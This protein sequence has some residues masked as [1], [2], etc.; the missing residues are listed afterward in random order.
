MVSVTVQAAAAG[1]EV[2]NLESQQEDLQREIAALRTEFAIQTS[3]SRMEKRAADLGFQAITPEDITYVIIPGYKGREP[4]VQA[5]PPGSSI[6]QPLIKPAY[7]QSLWEWM[8]Q[9]FLDIRER[10]GGLTP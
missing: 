7:T 3:S 8:L 5:S 1:L 4:D 6:Q 9:G 2:Q 10:P